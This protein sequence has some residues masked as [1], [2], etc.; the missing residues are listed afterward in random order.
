MIKVVAKSIVKSDQIE[1]YKNS[2]RE[3]IEKTRK[4]AGCISYQLFQD[5]KNAKVFTF[6]EEW[7]SEDALNKHMSSKHFQEI[8]PKLAQLREQNSEIN[9][10]RLVL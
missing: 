9:I 10:Y 2:V 1:T 7:E 8:V 3:L 4:E 6:I 5:I